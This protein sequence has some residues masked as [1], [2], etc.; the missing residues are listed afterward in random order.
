MSNLLILACSVIDGGLSRNDNAVT[1]VTS[2]SIFVQAHRG[3]TGFSPLVI[4]GDNCFFTLSWCPV[5]GAL[6][7]LFVEH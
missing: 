3:R 2:Y 1:Q 4:V 5:T 7:G 6:R